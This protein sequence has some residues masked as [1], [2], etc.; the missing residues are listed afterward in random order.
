MTHVEVYAGLVVWLLV[1]AVLY[2]SYT[3]EW[4]DCEI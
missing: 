3:L 4:E 2:T 1:D